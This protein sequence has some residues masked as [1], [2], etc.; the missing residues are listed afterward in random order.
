MGVLE[1][2]RL[3]PHTPPPP[4]WTMLSDFCLRLALLAP[5][6]KAMQTTNLTDTTDMR[7]KLPLVD[8]TFANCDLWLHMKK[9]S[10]SCLTTW[11]TSHSVL[12][13]AACSRHWRAGASARQSCVVACWTVC[14]R[15][16][17]TKFHPPKGE[18]PH[19]GGR[20]PR[21]RPSAT[22]QK[23]LGL[24]HT[25]TGESGEESFPQVSCTPKPNHL[26]PVLN[27]NKQRRYE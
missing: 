1:S 16:V 18:H 2:A 22:G 20:A 14:I 10:M 23:F 6:S 15:R 4:P 11:P 27:Q 13:M 12:P 24:A 17:L 19:W 9:T 5:T 26:Q 7:F 21:G 25:T 8:Q 3:F